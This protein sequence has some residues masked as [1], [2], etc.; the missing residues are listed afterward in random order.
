[1][2]IFGVVSFSFNSMEAD[3]SPSRASSGGGAGG[4]GLDEVLSATSLLVEL[5]VVA[6]LLDETVE[7]EGASGKPASLQAGLQSKGTAGR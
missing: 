1:M 3:V 6:S 7:V 5:E 4:G 2:A